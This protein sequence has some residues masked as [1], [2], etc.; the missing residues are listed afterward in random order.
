MS[1]PVEVWRTVGAIGGK[2]EAVGDWLRLFL[3]PDCPLEL[4]DS[5]RQQKTALMELLRLNF[6][7]VHSEALNTTV[8]WTSDEPTKAAL[9]AVGAAQNS[10]YTVAELQELVRKGVTLDE[11]LAIHATRSK[12]DGTLLSEATSGRIYDGTSR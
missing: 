12:F 10:I 5:I 8:F 9:V 4:K 3:P 11:L 2:L 1:T 7:T 6:W